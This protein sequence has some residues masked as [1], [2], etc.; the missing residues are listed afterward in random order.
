[1]KIKEFYWRLREFIYNKSKQK[2]VKTVFYGRP[3][4]FSYMLQ[5]ELDYMK[6]MKKYFDN[7]RF[8]DKSMRELNWAIN[9]LQLLLSDDYWDCQK[10]DDGTF[11]F[12]GCYTCKVHVNTKNIKRFFTKH[13]DMSEESYNNVI[14]YIL[15]HKHE[16][17][18]AKL[19]HLYNA[20][21]EQYMQNWWDSIID[22]NTE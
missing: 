20:I 8:T 7:S 3:F 1:M 13:S 4:D 16:V 5:V 6:Y 22:K 15:E 21:R 18:K 19:W 14:Q 9:I 10:Q 12:D 2:A 11:T 17:Y